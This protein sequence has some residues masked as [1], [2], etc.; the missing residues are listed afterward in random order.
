LC[1]CAV[2]FL[3]KYFHADM[4]SSLWA[5][6]FLAD[7]VPPYSQISWMGEYRPN[8]P[9]L[10]ISSPVTSVY[11]CWRILLQQPHCSLC[12]TCHAMMQKS[13]RL[14]RSLWGN[15]MWIGQ[16]YNCTV[17]VACGTSFMTL[18]G[19]AALCC[20]CIP[21]IPVTI[22]S[23]RLPVVSVI[24]VLYNHIGECVMRGDKCVEVRRC[25][26]TCLIMRKR[27]LLRRS[28]SRSQ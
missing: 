3:L 1:R 24:F 4:F 25:K 7:D 16:S 18:F 17:E 26:S 8:Y 2:V 10:D 22:K 19:R 20:N 23:E 14:L 11:S 15:L 21:Q 5:K 9:L 12:I 27:E 6:P 13:L 28:R